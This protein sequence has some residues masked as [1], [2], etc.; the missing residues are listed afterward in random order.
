MRVVQ[1]RKWY[2]SF[3]K[4]DPELTLRTPRNLT[5]SYVA[6][7]QQKIISW[8]K[9][10]EK[11]IQ[12]NGLEAIAFF[13]NPKGGG[14]LAEKITRNVYQKENRRKR[15]SLSSYTR[16]CA[17][18]LYPPLVCFKYERLPQDIVSSMPL[19][20]QLGKSASGWITGKDFFE[21]RKAIHEWQVQQVISKVD[22]FFK[23]RDF[24]KLLEAT[25]E[26]CVPP[27]ILK[28]CF[29][30]CGLY[31][32]DSSAVDLENVHL[33]NSPIVLTPLTAAR[34]SPPTAE[35]TKPT[36]PK[37]SAIPRCHCHHHHNH[38]QCE[39]VLIKKKKQWASEAAG[40]EWHGDK[41][42]EKIHQFWHFIMTPPS[43]QQ[44]E[45]T[46]PP[47]HSVTTTSYQSQ[48]KNNS[49]KAFCS[50]HYVIFQIFL[51][52]NTNH[53]KKR[54]SKECT[55]AVAS[56]NTWIEHYNKK[57]QAKTEIIGK[58]EERVKELAKKNKESMKRMR[59]GKVI[60]EDSKCDESEDD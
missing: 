49:S 11:Y 1:E 13:L 58:K 33:K 7:T 48:Q 32:W 17:G 2:D 36:L 9:E 8:L 52:Y 50:H 55:P 3:L 44:Q 29:Q 31:L 54:L 24:A 27:D 59:G 28:A 22:T 18:E 46:M 43:K 34:T 38:L 21:Y 60:E 53:T 40:E 19:D 26:K 39:K 25:L 10:V 37:S 47:T 16:K 6:V 51:F 5:A 30:K 15:V 14:V 42:N 20:W 57:L 56:L 45:N 12:E 41:T 4:R 23:K 35:V